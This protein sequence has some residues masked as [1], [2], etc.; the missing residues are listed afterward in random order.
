MKI[1]QNC[2]YYPVE[3]LECV[4]HCDKRMGTALWKKAKE[5]KLG[6]SHHGALTANAPHCSLIITM[7]SC[8]T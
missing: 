1:F 7:R 4:N 2:F 8:I 3:K 6:G 5:G